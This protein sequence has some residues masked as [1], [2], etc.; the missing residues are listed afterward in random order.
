MMINELKRYN[1]NNAEEA[2]SDVEHIPVQVAGY[3]G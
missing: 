3:Y 2:D 1:P